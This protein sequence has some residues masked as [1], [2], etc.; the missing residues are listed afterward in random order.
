M[1]KDFKISKTEGIC[2][3]SGEAIPPGEEFVAL[4]R[5]REDELIRE[6]YSL[7]GW[8][9]LGEEK[10]AEAPD[11]LGVWRTRTPTTQEKKKL[12]VDDGLLINFFERLEG[13]D[14]PARINFRYVL[15]LILMRKKLLIYEGTERNDD[16]TE[17]WKMRLK[18][19]DRVHEVIDPRMDDEKIA[20][21]SASLGEIMQGDFE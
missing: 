5:I 7:A 19:S 10:P 9:E 6:D 4:V 16:G 12:F 20:A 1:A 15:G 8:E 14:D 17:V 18:G 2:C 21:V 3:K 11:V 13:Q